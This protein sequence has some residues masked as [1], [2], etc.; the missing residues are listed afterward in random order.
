MPNSLPNISYPFPILI[1]DDDQLLRRILETNL[2]TAGYD[3]I[4]AAN[5]KD[6]LDIFKSGYY[7][8]VM[9]DWIMPE[10]DGLDLCRA[11]RKEDTE[12]YTYIILLTSL[13]SKNDIIAGL[14][15]GADEYLVKPV[16]Q[17]E[18]RTR[19]KTARRILELESNLQ[20]SLEKIRNL[21][22]VDPV[23]GIYNRHYMDD[24]MSQE[25]KRAYRYEHPLALI[26][27]KIN[28]FKDIVDTHGYYSGDQVLQACA[29]CLT[30]AVRK[31]VDWLVRYDGDE[32]LIVLPETDASGAMIV[33]KRFRIRI[34]TI[35]LKLNQHEIRVT[36]RFGVA[37]FSASKLKLG[38]TSQILLDKAEHCLNQ[39]NNEETETIKGVQLS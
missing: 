18:L 2:K 27:V 4:A 29:E 17:N 35:V 24:R 6:A 28:N 16:N 25:I 21:A 1:V 22:L 36:A 12:H 15:A 11:I 3:V 20:K 26:L 32:F 33:A 23:T 31:G 14:E 39:A 10:M 9:T 7:P 19:L 8:I 34:S 30:D 13:D 5:G 37:S 38:I